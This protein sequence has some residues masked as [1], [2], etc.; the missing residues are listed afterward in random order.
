MMLL[1]YEPF[2]I[3]GV[4]RGVGAQGDRAYHYALSQLSAGGN[5]PFRDWWSEYPP[6][7]YFLTTAVYQLLGANVNYSSW[8]LLLGSFLIA[9]DA[10]NLILIRKIGTRLHGASTGVSLAWIYAVLFAPLVF[11]WWEFELMVTFWLLLGLSW[12]LERRDTR[13]ALAVAIGAL[14]KFTPALLFGAAFRFRE[15]PAALRYAVIGAGTFA[16]AYVPLLAQNAAMTL[17]SLTAQF[18][19]SSYQTVWALI[20]GNYRTGIFGNVASHFDPAQAFV[21]TGNPAVIPGFARLAAAATVGVYVYARTR[22]FDDRGLVGFVGITVLIFF[23]Q[24]QGWSPQCV[25]Q[26][27]PLVLLAIPTRNG[28]L[29]IVLLSLLSLA[30]YPFLF[31][32]TADTGGVIAGALVMPFVML[33]LARTAILVALCVALYRCLRQEPANL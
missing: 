18:R 25:V 15:L 8:S 23:L 7:W 11:L 2:I 17:P 4:E 33:V 9:F 28:I 1:A 27:I 14:T 16:L 20:D 29:A 12:L 31:I 6:V 26:I 10:G 13:S 32:R 3:D 21:L 19:K 30:E 22:R 24:A 5:L